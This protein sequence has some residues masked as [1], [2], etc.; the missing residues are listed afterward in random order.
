MRKRKWQ[1]PRSSPTADMVIAAYAR[2][3]AMTIDQCA[4]VTG[5]HTERIRR[6]VKRPAFAVVGL[7]ETM[8]PSRVW[9]LKEGG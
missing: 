5:L 6:V 2:H 7:V 4:Q 3:G 8:P 9:E 1:T